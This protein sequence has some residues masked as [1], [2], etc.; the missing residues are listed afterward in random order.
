MRH[1]T[2]AAFWLFQAADPEKERR[3]KVRQGL[4]NG[5]VVMKHFKALL[6]WK[7]PWTKSTKKD[8]TEEEIDRILQKLM[9]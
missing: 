3:S 1:A 5:N 7:L 4:L 8:I 6:D 2:F 9:A